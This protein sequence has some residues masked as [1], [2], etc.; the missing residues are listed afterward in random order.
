MLLI[1]DALFHAQEDWVTPSCLLR[2]SPEHP[3]VLNLSR[4]FTEHSSPLR[5]HE[6]LLLIFIAANT[7]H[8]VNTN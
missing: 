5:D 4:D 8:D 6:L 1:W 2:L 7:V 3:S